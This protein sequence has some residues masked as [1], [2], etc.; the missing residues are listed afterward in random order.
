[1]ADVRVGDRC[2]K[3]GA[4]TVAVS[5]AYWPAIQDASDRYSMKCTECDWK[6]DSMT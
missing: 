6:R 3:C 1:M 2:P 4:A 5:E